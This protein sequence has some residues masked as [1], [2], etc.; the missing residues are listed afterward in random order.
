LDHHLHGAFQNGELYGS[1]NEYEI[2]EWSEDL[3]LAV[4]T[5]PVA[6]LEHRIFPKTKTAD[7]IYAEHEDPNVFS[8]YVLE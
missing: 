4:K 2:R 5:M 1:C 8:R 7:R 3:I 6:T